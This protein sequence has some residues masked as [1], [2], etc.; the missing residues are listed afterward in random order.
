MNYF[1]KKETN[2]I[3]KLEK[4]LFSKNANFDADIR[5]GFDKKQYEENP[6]WDDGDLLETNLNETLQVKKPKTGTFWIIFSAAFLFFV[7]SL[8]YAAYVFIAGERVVSTD[9]ISIDIVGPVS[10]S[11]GSKVSID[12]I[13]QNNGL[14]EMKDANFVIDYPEGT[15]SVDLQSELKRG[16]IDVGDIAVGS[17]VKKTLD[18]AFLGENGEIKSVDISAEY[19]TPGSIA[20]LKKSKS[21]TIT[22]SVSPVQIL[23]RTV[24]R[25]SSGQKIDFDLEIKSNSEK[26]INNL[27]VTAEYPFGF[28]FE[29]A[30]IEPTYG[31]NIWE[32]KNFNPTDIKN[33]IISGEIQAQDNEQRAFRFSAGTPKLENREEIGIALTSVRNTILIEKPFV[34]LDLA[35]NGSKESV[36]SAQSGQ[37]INY[38]LNLFNNTK[39]ILR[40]IEVRLYLDGRALNKAGVTA[41]DG[42]YDSNSNQIVYTKNTSEILSS[43]SPE[44]NVSVRGTLISYDLTL[45]NRNLINPEIRISAVINGT[46][47]SET[48]ASEKIEEKDFVT[49]KILSDVLISSRISYNSNYT[50]FAGFTDSGPIPPK[51]GV[52]TFYTASWILTNN[53]NDIENTKV[54]GTLPF[55]VE[56]VGKYAPSGEDIVFD[57]NTRRIIWNA[58]N[59]SAGVGYSSPIKFVIFQLK[60]KPSVSQVEQQPAL[61]E[62][63]NLSTFDT[64]AKDKIEKNIDNSTTLL[65]GQSTLDKHGNVVQ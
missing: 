54:I 31:N 34:G 7:F 61:I 20:L 30:S 9:N 43:I 23:V 46:R 33:I 42:F 45:N 65:Y 8:G 38:D 62:K 6:D 41:A 28:K 48:G 1:D 39:D 64:F 51:V 40:D 3:G 35:V 29:K 59:V 56:W 32:F 24:D 14:V 18:M 44:T 58:K 55:Y 2:R 47:I 63:I 25:I 10:A 60:L 5:S 11:G 4:K 22:L 37:K 50:R 15:R 13:L 53:V 27:L 52:D 21:F 49:V 19:K 36:V 26:T 12:V 57:D 16:R 17:V